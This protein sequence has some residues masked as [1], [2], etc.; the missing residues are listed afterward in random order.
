MRLGSTDACH[1][2]C[3]E[4]LKQALGGND[5][6][7]SVVHINCEINHGM[8]F[9]LISPKLIRKSLFGRFYQKCCKKLPSV[10]NRLTVHK[11]ATGGLEKEGPNARR[12]G[13]HTGSNH[14]QGRGPSSV[15]HGWL[16]HRETCS[17]P[18]GAHHR[19]G[20]IVRGH[21]NK[22]YHMIRGFT[23]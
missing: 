5:L 11:G 1:R 18:P 7:G 23:R 16:P 8:G 22:V 9:W 2:V 14:M 19:G 15:S 4:D 12:Q 20:H 13:S 21:D 17:Q 6:I 3:A 10:Q